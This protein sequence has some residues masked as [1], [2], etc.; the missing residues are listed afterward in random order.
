LI[1][2]VW[3]FSYG[4]AN[5]SAGV[6]ATA[7]HNSS[8]GILDLFFG[9]LFLIFLTLIL[10]AIVSRI[11]R[12]N[13]QLFIVCLFM[14]ISVIIINNGSLLDFWW[15]IAVILPLF[16]RRKKIR[17]E[18]IWREVLLC[19]LFVLVISY[20]LNDILISAIISSIPVSII[21][22]A[23]DAISVFANPYFYNKILLIIVSGIEFMAIVGLSLLGYGIIFGIK[24]GNAKPDRKN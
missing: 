12:Y 2:P 8:A 13:S 16:I 21:I 9:G 17:F 15:P 3:A 19:A 14:V 24:H 4:Y 7:I 6:V 11:P 20:L 1:S 18:T 5:K 23:C 22:N 10:I